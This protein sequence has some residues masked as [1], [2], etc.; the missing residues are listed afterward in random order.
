MISNAYDVLSDSTKKAQ[1][2]DMR[3]QMRGGGGSARSGSGSSSYYNQ[4]GA[5]EETTYTYDG[6]GNKRYTYSRYTYNNTN[7]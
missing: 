5:E 3:E 1:Y 2:D 7:Q 4:P 6:Q